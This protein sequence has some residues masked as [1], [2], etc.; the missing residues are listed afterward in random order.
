MHGMVS[1]A[2]APPT[3]GTHSAYSP[4]STRSGTGAKVAK[5]G[6]AASSVLL[7]ALW[8]LY[9]GSTLITLHRRIRRARV[10]RIRRTLLP[11]KARRVVRN[12]GRLHFLPSILIRRRSIATGSTRLA[13][14]QMRRLRRR[15][16][17]CPRFRLYRSSH[18]VALLRAGR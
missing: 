18:S 11:R 9:L 3:Y 4:Y 13:R 8:F 1:D 5:P 16:L 12:R 7:V 15:W 10:R 6:L 17:A 14:C 2:F